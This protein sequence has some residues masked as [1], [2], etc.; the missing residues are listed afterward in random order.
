M[1]IVTT[2]IQS[3]DQIENRCDYTKHLILSLDNEFKVKIENDI[4]NS[5]SKNDKAIII[6]FAENT[7]EDVDDF[8]SY[9][10]FFIKIM[11]EVDYVSIDCNYYS[12]AFQLLQSAA[13]SS[14]QVKGINIYVNG[15][16]E[17]D[18]RMDQ[19]ENFLNK[20]EKVYF[21]QGLFDS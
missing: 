14:K 4:C 16:I 17:K 3:Y 15:P 9:F 20:R 18:Y 12:I 8:Y 19:D 6:T 1:I 7:L 11:H 13:L 21:R 10:H 5:L 2:D